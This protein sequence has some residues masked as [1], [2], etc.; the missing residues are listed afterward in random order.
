MTML[1][2]RRT[3]RNFS[4]VMIV[5]GLLSMGTLASAATDKKTTTPAPAPAPARPAPAAAPAPRPAGNPGGAVNRPTNVPSTSQPYRPT[6]SASQPYNGG[7]S[8]NHP[9]TTSPTVNGGRNTTYGTS[10]GTRTPIRASTVVAP[11][12]SR[13][14]KA[15]NG[16][17]LRLRSD[18]RPSDVHDAQRGMDIHHGLNGGQRAS[19]ERPDHSR[20][21]LLYTS[22]GL[23]PQSGSVRPKH[24]TAS[25]FAS[26][27]SH[28]S[29]WASVPKV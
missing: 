24:P 6:P 9:T 27:G 16:N 2:T 26:A 25:P 21:C 1:I 14:M 23:L 28:S 22:P 4:A 18:G 20:T 10:V 17:A 19:V 8:A 15:P 5:A 3:M 12:N 11:R 29:F 7:P 13:E